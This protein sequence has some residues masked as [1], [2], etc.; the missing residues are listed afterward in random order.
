[1]K[2]TALPAFNDNYIWVMHDATEA[3]CIDPGES[4]QVIDYLQ[5][6]HL[7]LKEI[8]LTHHHNDHIGGV[9][10][11]VA[12]Y[13]DVCI[14]APDDARIPAA[15]QR[16]KEG[17]RFNFAGNE[18]YALETPAHTSTHISFVG[19]ESAFTGDTLFS[20][21]CGRLFEGSPQQMLSSLEKIARLPPH[22][23]VYCGHEYTEANARFAAHVDPDNTE[24]IDYSEKIRALRTQNQPSLPSTIATELAC[25]PFLRCDTQPVRDS[26]SQYTGNEIND[27]VTAFTALREWKNNF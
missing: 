6:H 22:F 25:N 26:V 12:A 11:L 1:M 21:G 16:M 27:T 9:Q 13:P 17:D 7:Q 19:A 20:L 23:K 8:W 18:F 3:V 15:T 4:A 2:I 14:R 10:Q 24:L 5:S